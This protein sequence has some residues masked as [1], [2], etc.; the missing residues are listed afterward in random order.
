[1]EASGTAQADQSLSAL[2]GRISD[3]VRE[4]AKEHVAL[5]R[6]EVSAQLRAILLDAAMLVLGGVVALIGLALLCCSV[7]PALEPW[8]P[9]LWLRMVVMAIAYVAIAGALLSVFA[10]RM[11]DDKLDLKRSKRQAERTVKT[12]EQKV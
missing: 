11:R 5:A 2:A 10:A 7:V 3:D 6:A 4:L 8:V 9:Q 1:M 12:I